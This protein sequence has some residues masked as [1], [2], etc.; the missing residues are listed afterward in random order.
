MRRLAIEDRRTDATL[1]PMKVFVTGAAGFVGSRLSKALLARGDTVI[2][3]DNFNDYYDIAHKERHLA[4]CATNKALHVRSKATCAMP[5]AAKLMQEHK[6]DAIAHLAAMAAVRYSIDHPADL[7][8]SERAGLDEP[9][10][11][12]ATRRQT[13][14]CVLAS[15]GSRLWLDTPVPFKE[16]AAADRP[17]APYPASKRAMELMAHS[18]SPSLETADDRRAILQRLRPA[19]P[20][21]HDALAMDR[22]R[23]SAASPSRSTTA[24]DEAR[25]DLH[26]RHRRRVHRGAGSTIWNSRY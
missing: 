9:D 11:R 15:T 1:S 18:L 13:A 5:T 7:R 21:G 8:R 24:E 12:R 3:F 20:A 23:S 6:P 2:G 16:D 25:L 22:R 19:R 10:R 17:L 26:R 14:D 4:T